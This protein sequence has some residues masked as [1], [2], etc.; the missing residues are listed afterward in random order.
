MRGLLSV[1]VGIALMFACL[2]A[3]AELVFVRDGESLALRVEPEKHCI[4]YPAS[5][6]G[7]GCK[8]MTLK[9][10][11]EYTAAPESRLVAV[12]YERTDN[13]SIELFVTQATAKGRD[14]ITEQE[15]NAYIAKV[16]DTAEKQ[17]TVLSFDVQPITATGA[18]APHASGVI[19]IQ[20]DGET[21]L[22]AWDVLYA[23]NG[24]YAFN[25]STNERNADR[26]EAWRKALLD[27]TQVQH[28]S[29]LK[30]KQATTKAVP[31]PA[32]QTDA[33]AATATAT[34]TD[35]ISMILKAFGSM[36]MVG[37]AGIVRAFM[38]HKE[39]RANRAANAPGAAR[40]PWI[41]NPNR[42]WSPGDPEHP[43]FPMDDP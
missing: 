31:A 9:A 7:A 43:P 12:V 35:P 4:A 19:R 38:A 15:A 18:E 36:G 11:E 13:D 28:P 16:K 41:V 8:G 26:L 30:E 37:A 29:W 6:R 1:L 3:H 42:P 40:L 2:D 14:A 24:N 32:P 23:T 39:S 34:D 10:P 33:P 17:G 21:H 22:F 5:L 25:W 20:R 27:T